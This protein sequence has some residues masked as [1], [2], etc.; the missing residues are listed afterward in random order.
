[1]KRLFKGHT[2]FGRIANIVGDENRESLN[3]RA[4]VRPNYLRWFCGLHDL[5]AT[6]PC[7]LL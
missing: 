1:M 4:D 2:Y 6:M 5:D 3:A 7:Q